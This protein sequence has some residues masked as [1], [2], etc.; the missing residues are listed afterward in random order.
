MP[1]TCQRAALLR[2]ARPR[3]ARRR[4]ALALALLSATPLSVGLG[5]GVTLAPQTARADAAY[6][7][8]PEL[9]EHAEVIAV[10]QTAWVE[11]T[12]VK[13]DH[14]TYRQ[15]ARV[16]R[17]LLI[18][19]HMRRV[20][21]IL[22]E[23]DFECARASYQPAT[24]YLVFLA[25]DEKTG[26]LVTLNHG[27]GNILV[28]DEG[29][30]EWSYGDERGHRS[31]EDVVAELRGMVPPPPPLD[32]SRY[33][34][35]PAAAPAPA[36]DQAIAACECAEPTSSW[37]PSPLLAVGALSVMLGFAAGSALGRRRKR[38]APPR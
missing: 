22:A 21:R 31:L 19:G 6:M 24:R 3:R 1:R 29:A 14:W 12:D 16:V 4:A 33:A 10:V 26:E 13:G 35:P 37:G 11:E 32:A 2:P 8:L 27:A 17:E 34:A 36:T 18:K 20:D 5:V 30:L 7:R 28:D 38:T 9:V 25:R 15:R 23:K